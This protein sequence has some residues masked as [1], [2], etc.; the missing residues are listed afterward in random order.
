MDVTGTGPYTAKQGRKFGVTL[1]IAFM[2]LAAVVLWRGHGSVGRAFGI[3]GGFLLVAGLT[4]PRGLRPIERGWMRFAGV[5]S[6]VT[7]PIFMGIVFYLVI[8]PVG[9]VRRTAGKDPL[10][11]EGDDSVWAEHEGSNDLRRQF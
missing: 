2:V 6:R 10:E 11:H 4:V 9:L 1:G 5:L 7:T 3:V 8:T